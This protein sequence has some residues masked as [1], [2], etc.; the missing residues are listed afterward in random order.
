[1]GWLFCPVIVG[2]VATVPYGKG[3]SFSS[4]LFCTTVVVSVYSLIHQ[5]LYSPL[6]GPGLFFQC[7]IP[8]HSRYDSL[9]RGSARCKAAAYTQDSTN[10]E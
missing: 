3:F 5:W 8:V 2:S 4:E 7:R 1:M 9:N 10:T 6:L